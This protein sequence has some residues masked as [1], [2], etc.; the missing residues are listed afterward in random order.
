MAGVAML[1]GMAVAMLVASQM[2]FLAGVFE[3]PDQALVDEVGYLMRTTAVYGS[4]KF[5]AADREAIARRGHKRCVDSGYSW[6]ALMRRDWKRVLEH[7][8]ARAR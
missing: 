6:D 7:Y 5:G 2:P 8:Q 4:G 1:A 3:Q